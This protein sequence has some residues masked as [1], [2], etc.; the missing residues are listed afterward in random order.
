MEASTS[1]YPMK[2]KDAPDRFVV[3]V[4]ERKEHFYIKKDQAE[5][6]S[7]VQTLREALDLNKAVLVSTAAD[8][9]DRILSVRLE[10]PN[11]RSTPKCPDRPEMTRAFWTEQDAVAGPPD[12]VRWVT[13]SPNCSSYRVSFFRAHSNY[14][15]H[16]QHPRAQ[17]MLAF[18]W[19]SINEDIQ[20]KVSLCRTAR[21][22]LADLK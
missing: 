22:F 6:L 2:L 15:I 1:I 16:E 14:W 8:E 21:A 20:V 11:E 18:A 10:R 5:T 17:E 3:V 19:K 4:L 9:P 12:Y 13:K 7:A